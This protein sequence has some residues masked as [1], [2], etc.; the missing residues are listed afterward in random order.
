MPSETQEI[1]YDNLRVHEPA[2]DK[3]REVQRQYKIKRGVL[4]TQS[5]ALTIIADA[6]LVVLEAESPKAQ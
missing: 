6:Y 4:P 1:S 2:A 5:E 3:L